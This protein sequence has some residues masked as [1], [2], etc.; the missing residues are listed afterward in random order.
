M[1]VFPF[2]MVWRKCHYLIQETESWCNVWCGGNVTTLLKK[3]S[4][5][6]ITITFAVEESHYLIQETQSRWY[7]HYIWC[8]GHATT[9]FKKLSHVGTS[10]TS[11]VEDVLLPNSRN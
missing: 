4:H 8:G 9:Q 2:Q 10:I 3:L 5:G 7:N 6:G 1:V 11:D